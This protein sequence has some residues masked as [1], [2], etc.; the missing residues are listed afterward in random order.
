LGKEKKKGVI[1]ATHTRPDL[2]AV[3]AMWLIETFG[4]EKMKEGVHLFLKSGD[5]TLTQ[6]EGMIIIDRGRGEFDHHGRDNAAG[7][8][9]A[10]LVAKK[11]GIIERKSIQQLLSIV[12]RSDLQGISES[13]DISDIIKCMQRD[14]RIKDEE[15]IEIGKRIVEDTVEFRERGLS[16]DNQWLREVIFDFLKGK[17]VL[18]PKFQRYLEVLSNPRFERHFD[19]VE[20]SVAEREKNGEEK[21]REFLKK[22][23]EIEY[24]D[25]AEY[26]EALEIVKGAWKKRVREFQI[27]A[28]ITDNTKFNQAARAQGA[29]IVIQRNGDGHTQIYF[30]TGKVPESLMDN[31]AAVIRLE[32]CLAM[33]RPI[34]KTDLRKP[35]WIEDIPWYYYQAPRLKEKRKK[36][37]RFILNGSLTA[38]DIQ[39]S[40]IN[41]EDLLY[42][43][44]CA[45]RYEKINWP[46]W[47]AE[48]IAHY[49]SPSFFI[50]TQLLLR[51]IRIFS[52]FLLPLVF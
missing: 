33:N 12:R 45:V 22:I 37:G 20:I 28:A 32:E 15:I 49:L 19:L 13:F 1:K 34:P 36:P 26:L 30:D 41:W 11:L 40:K 2:D 46:R 48:R 17:M 10:Y 14:R 44:E 16:R 39:P 52:L 38:P 29:A 5:E 31:I 51:L 3:A 6:F 23:L 8:T 18:P 50:S 35:G 24:N 4:N 42:I 27:I 43:V 9:S 21:A 47:M 7:E 25:S